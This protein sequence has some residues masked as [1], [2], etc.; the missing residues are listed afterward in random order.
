[1]NSFTF[2]PL[3]G[4]KI[5]AALFALLAVGLNFSPLA[6]SLVIGIPPLAEVGAGLTRV[7][8]DCTELVAQ[9]DVI[10]V[11]LVAIMFHLKMFGWT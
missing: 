5:A 7:F 2:S 6:G 3:A 4:L 9:L 10:I 11:L 1:M 8:P